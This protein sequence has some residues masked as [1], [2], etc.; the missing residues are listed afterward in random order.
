[1]YQ[2]KISVFFRIPI[3]YIY[4]IKINV[5]FLVLILCWKLLQFRFIFMLFYTSVTHEHCT[6]SGHCLWLL[7]RPLWWSKY[8]SEW[9]SR[10]KILKNKKH[11]AR[12]YPPPLP[13]DLRKL[14]LGNILCSYRRYLHSSSL[15]GIPPPFFFFTLVNIFGQPSIQCHPMPPPP[16]FGKRCYVPVSWHL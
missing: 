7:L 10:M 11:L 3:L 9:S 16:F 4:R 6:F 12:Y 8:C 15:K 1:M 5:C 13:S 2:Y 14:D